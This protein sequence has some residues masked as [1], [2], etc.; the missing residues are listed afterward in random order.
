MSLS[1]KNQS[2]C[3][4]SDVVDFFGC[5]HAAFLNATVK[6]ENS[7]EEK[8]EDWLL[9]KKGL[10]HEKTYLQKLIEEGRRVVE[11]PSNLSFQEGLHRTAEA[12]HSGADA[13]YQA[14]F[15]KSPWR[16][17]ADFLIKH[18][19]SSDLGTFS[20]EVLETKLAHNPKPKHLLQLCIYSNLLTNFQELQPQRMH[21]YLGNSSYHSFYLKDFLYYGNRIRKQFESFIQNLPDKSVPEPCYHCQSCHWKSRCSEQWIKEDHLSLVANIQRSQRN[22]LKK[23]GIQSVSNLARTS[24][25][26]KIPNLNQEVFLRLRSQAILQKEKTNKGKNKYRILPFSVGKGFCRLPKPNEGDLFFD[27]E[28]DPFYPKGLE[29]LFGIQQAKQQAF[30]QF[31]SHNHR[32]E[33]ESFHL[34]MNFIEEHL[35]NH[36]NSYIY[37]YNHYEPTAL[38]RLAC[39]YALKEEL[40]DN[41]LR[42]KKFVDLYTVVRESLL[43]SEPGYSLKN[44]ET[45]YRDQRKDTVATAKDS[46]VI[47]N[48]W[49]ETGDNSLLK[50]LADYNETDCLS[51]QQLRD[52]LLKLRPDDTPWFKS[53]FEE[54]P[55]RK[56]WEKEYEQYQQRLSKKETEKE[57]CEKLCSLLEFHNREAKS[58]WWS[59]FDRQNKEEAELI[60]DA[61]SLGGLIMTREPEKAGQSLIYTYKFPPQ[62]YKLK[63]GNSIVNTATMEKAGTIVTMDALKS[64]VQI[65]HSM[66]RKTLPKRF[67]IGPGQP[68]N[69]K[70]IRSAI[71]RLA[72]NVIRGENQHQCV[73]DLLNRSLPRFKNKEKKTSPL[74]S[75]HLQ[76]EVLDAV[77]NLNESYLFIQGTSRGRQ[78]LF[79]QSHNC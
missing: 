69:C 47:Y 41:L 2:F 27:M 40:L 49:R 30:K 61:E 42:E 45:F 55:P 3:S 64:L 77:S 22:K 78:N 70:G 7:K 36:P 12:A 62:E 24:E 14:A 33:K 63:V 53:G 39:C 74:M 35:K 76:Q 18:S 29:Y 17:Q 15:L 32:E 66:K 8:E 60:E 38:K 10:E 31:W 58:Q 72:D 56:E 21:L 16:G 19:T 20:Y 48:R 65:K 51:T 34:C 11:I 37:H 44:L 50:E 13:I 46:I 67:S 4:P 43:I 9:K 23:A 1:N 71:Y 28:G 54:P 79:E 52:W 57:L 6:R 26:Q 5:R 75:Y 68:I 25:N 73:K 59:C